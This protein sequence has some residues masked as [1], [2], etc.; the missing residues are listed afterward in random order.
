VFTEQR[1][2]ISHNARIIRGSNFIMASRTLCNYDI[3]LDVVSRDADDIHFLLL[4]LEG[5][6]N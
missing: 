3:A 4:L 6:R 1:L 5:E 2:Q